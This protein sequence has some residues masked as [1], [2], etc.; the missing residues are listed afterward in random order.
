MAVGSAFLEAVQSGC[1]L[2]SGF[3]ACLLDIDD[4]SSKLYSPKD[5]CSPIS[6]KMGDSNSSG[7]Y[8]Q[9]GN[10]GC[11]NSTVKQATV[12]QRLGRL[13]AVAVP[14]W[15]GS[16]G[17]S[18]STQSKGR[19]SEPQSFRGLRWADGRVRVESALPSTRLGR[20]NARTRAR[21]ATP[22]EEPGQAPDQRVGR[23]PT[24]RPQL[25]LP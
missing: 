15:R 5:R 14:R 16:S 13:F 1:S 24:N 2:S 21:V 7:R 25:G 10:S 20:G 6:Q 22:E 17:T 3:N 11:W 19:H 23:L 8:D 18:G 9:T 4:S 12:R